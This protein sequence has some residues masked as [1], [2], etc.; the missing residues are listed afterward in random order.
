MVAQGWRLPDAPLRASV[1]TTQALGLIAVLAMAS[2]MRA[3]LPLGAWYPLKASAIFALV[4][5]I[6][7]GFVRERHPYARFGAANQATTA[8][9]VLAALVVSFLGES[10][11]PAL[12]ASTAVVAGVATGLDGVDGWLA[13]RSRMASEFGA[14]FDMEID[15]LLVLALA[16]IVWQHGKAG[17]W[18]LFIGLVR[19]LFVV[20]GWLWPWLRRPLPSSRRRQTI[21][22]IQYA[23]L[24]L[25]IA[26][27]VTMPFSSLAAAVALAALG[28]S[29]WVD[30]VWLWRNASA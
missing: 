15:A 24:G 20:G 28:Y 12:A 8:R 11:V 25:A 3:G 19:Y 10:S 30:I 5:L 18:V 21:C 7:V 16:T 4:M 26:P 13:R 1:V 22:V 27:V 9:A 29:F 14:R 17:P 6:T 2:T 23:G